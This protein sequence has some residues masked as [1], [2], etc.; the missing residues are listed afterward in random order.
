MESQHIIIWTETTLV[1][2]LADDCKYDAV[3][4]KLLKHTLPKRWF[5]KRW[6]R[7]QDMLNMLGLVS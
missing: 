4:N 1:Q 7:E 3:P 5:V 2:S 6:L